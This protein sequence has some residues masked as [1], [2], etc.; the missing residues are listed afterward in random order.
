M[1]DLQTRRVIGRDRELR[2][3]T[4]LVDDVAAGR[5]SRL[6]LSGVSGVGRSTL[7]HRV[8]AAAHARGVAAAVASCSPVEAEVPYGAVSQL[9]AGL[10]PPARFAEL[11]TAC[12]GGDCATP[13]AL[14]CD[15][16]TELARERP[17]VLAIDDLQWADSWSLAWFDAMARCAHEAPVLLVSAAHDRLSRYLDQPSSVRELTLDPLG[18]AETTELLEGALG[19]PAGE[20]FAAAVLGVTR[21][22]PAVLRELADRFTERG[23]PPG[24]EQIPELVTLARAVTTERAARLVRGLPADSLELL[25][26][27][28][29]CGTELGFEVAGSL[30]RLRAESLPDALAHLVASGLVTASDSPRLADPHL[31][32]DVLAAMD[33][34]ARAELYLR[35]AELGRRAGA[36]A[37]AVADLLCAA[38]PVGRSWAAAVLTEASAQRFRQGRPGPAAEALRR[39]LAEPMEPGDRGAVLTRLAAIEVATAPDASDGRL[40]Q[41]LTSPELRSLPSVVTAADLLLARGDAETTRQAAS[42]LCTAPEADLRPGRGDAEAGQAVSGLRSLPE[43]GSLLPAAD[44]PPGRGA[45]ETTHP[46]TSEPRTSPELSTAVARGEVEAARYAPSELESSREVGSLS[47]AAHL[48]LAPGEV[49][50]TREA[51]SGLESSPEVGSLS[52]AARLPLAPG[53]VEAAREAASGLGSSREVGALPIAADLPLAPG[54][55]EATREAVSGVSSSSGMSSHKFAADL[56]LARGD[57]ETTRPVASEPRA[58]VPALPRSA[59]AALSALG[60]LAQEEAS[61]EPELP[62][63][64]LPEPAPGPAQA[65]VAAWRLATRAEHRDRVRELARTAL[66]AR[67]DAPMMPRVAACRALMCCHDLDEATAGLT[68][69]VTDARRREARPVA[70]QAL[71]YRAVAAVHGDRPEETVLDLAAAER[72]LPPGSWHPSLVSRR[73]AGELTALVRLGRLDEAR[74]L[75]AAPVPH[76][77]ENGVGWAFLLY[78]R[79]EL[80]RATGEPESALSALRECGRM[81]RSRHWVNP[82]LVPWR[83]M[84]GIALWQLREPDAAET[85][86]AEELAIARR[87]GTGD[88][89]EAVRE[90]AL[91]DAG[92]GVPAQ[93]SR[94]V[95]P[96]R[97]PGSSVDGLSP[98]ERDVAALAADGLANREI[99]ERLSIALRTVELRLTKVYRKLGVKGRSGLAQRWAATRR[100]G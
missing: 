19:V 51:A 15:A 47:I 52:A 5:S 11:A 1:P 96:V 20:A 36:G 26:M 81:L 99:A 93:A 42:E 41:I 76:G 9:I 84:A 97:N 4:A 25:R 24:P 56:P 31:G 23:L 29:V 18:A 85:L 65:G 92:L 67:D 77:A 61:A 13:V 62:V 10:Y 37:P 71:L 72:E 39:A 64:P 50:A 55:V 38:P 32:A 80:A 87:W 45:L 54:E 8:V 90:R 21:G 91:A 2:V 70:A 44:F 59:A 6:A 3:I 78:A 66:A 73:I 98:G 88:V 28:A 14:L 7:L 53:E 75:A 17:V 12:F 63:T 74:H 79:A 82:M 94:P 89:L 83:T 40:R 46:A 16:F 58:P 57:A 30:A 60:W 34:D 33:P 68:E 49:E 95:E 43:V 22:R 48:P 27:L 35:A 69:L 100:E 86:F